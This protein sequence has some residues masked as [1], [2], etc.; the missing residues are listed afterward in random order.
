MTRSTLT[1]HEVEVIHG[2]LIHLA[3]LAPPMKLMMGNLVQNLRDFLNQLYEIPEGDGKRN[4]CLF[5]VSSA[6]TEDLR[7][8]VAL[9]RETFK[10]PLP[11]VEPECSPGKWALE[12]FTDISGHVMANPSIGIYVPSQSLEDP[13]VASIAFPKCFLEGKDNSGK[14]V[15]CKTTALEALGILTTL[16]TD[17]FRF[18]GREVSFVNDN[19]STVIAFKKGYSRDQWTTCIVKASR[20]VAAKLCADIYVTWE[21]RRSSKG[22]KIADNLTHNILED[23][24]NE[25]VQTYLK[26][27]RVCFP[28]PILEWMDRP[29]PD[30]TLGARVVCWL[31]EEYPALNI[32][33]Q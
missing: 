17:P 12:A 21:P 31:F 3:Q 20:V 25:E 14:N 16:A 13:L 9:L 32:I 4:K 10:S 24:S 5:Q 11:I 22:S 33:I 23:L 18:I 28:K 19:I 29:G 30:R 1:V 8:F 7:N 27:G 15:Y 26:M 6:L 2:K